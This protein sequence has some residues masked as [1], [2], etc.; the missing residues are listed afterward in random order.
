RRP[1]ASVP[2]ISILFDDEVEYAR[3]GVPFDRVYAVHLKSATPTPRG[4]S[5]TLSLP[6]GLRADSTVR[7]AAL[8][9]FGSTTLMFR[10]RGTLPTGRFNVS[11]SAASGGE[12]FVS[13]YLP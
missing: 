13:G 7:R 11:A 6:S 1:V 12:T 10:V 9:P 8:E 3:A 5:V 4:V 2:A